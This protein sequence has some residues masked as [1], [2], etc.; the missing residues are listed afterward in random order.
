MIDQLEIAQ[1]IQREIIAELLSEADTTDTSSGDVHSLRDP[2][3]ADWLGLT[4][5]EGFP[6]VNR[7]PGSRIQV[8]YHEQV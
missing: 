5:F 6:V 7:P 1:D 3:K 4:Y 8:V 2:A